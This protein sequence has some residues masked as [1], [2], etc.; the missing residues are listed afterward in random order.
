MNASQTGKIIRAKKVVIAA[1]PWTN[2]V[3]ECLGY[4]IDAEVWKVH[5]GYY[6]LKSGAQAPQW[7]HFG[8]DNGLYYGFPAKEPGLLSKVCRLRLV[9]PFELSPL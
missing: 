5:W 9:I 1:G 3:L 6:Q 4:E 2:K 7:F 8:K